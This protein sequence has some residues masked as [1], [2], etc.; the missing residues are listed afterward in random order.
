MHPST[1]TPTTYTL[2]EVMAMT[3]KRNPYRSDPDPRSVPQDP[4]RDPGRKDREMEPETDDPRHGR[5]G[6]DS[7]DRPTSQPQQRPD[8]KK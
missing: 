6:G 8:K 7:E 1:Y 4:G 2:E 3:E 5:E